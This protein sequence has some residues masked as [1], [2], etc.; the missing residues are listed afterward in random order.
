MKRRDDLNRN[1]STIVDYA[2]KNKPDI[3]LIA[4][5]VFDKILPTNASRVFLTSKI[6]LLKDANIAVFIIGGNHDVP[7]FGAFP[8]LAIDVL[9]S[10]GIA[11]VFSRSDIIQKKIVKVDGR[12]VCVSGRSYYTKFEGENPLKDVV[13]PLEGDYN[14]LLIHGALKGLNVASSVPEFAYQN[15][16]MADDI[17]KGLNYLALGHFHNH[18]EREHK[19]CKIVNPGSIEKLSWAEIDDEKGFVWAELDGSEV[20]TEFVRLETRPMEI[21]QLS[22]SKNEKYT[23]GIKNYVLDFLT[24]IGEPEKILKLSLGGLISHNQYNQLKINELLR[25]C[26]DLFFNLLVDRREL[27]IEGYGRVF[28]ERLENPVQAYSKRLD[29]LISKLKPDDPERKL[30]E[31]AK[32][33]GIKYLEATK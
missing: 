13:V 26:H 27:E 21:S 28:M 17:R 2:L 22:L 16:F 19:G 32:S 29:I 4:G 23:K 15:P 25:A 9:G 12:S 18:F 3:F 20:S 8:S 31:S 24:Q 33:L 1:F 6:K 30:L 11:T 5:D 14:I 10:A 7:R